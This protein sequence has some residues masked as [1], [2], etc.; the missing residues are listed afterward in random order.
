MRP[1]PRALRRVRQRG[2]CGAGTA[3]RPT[4]R[5]P[6]AWPSS[7][8]TSARSTTTTSSTRPRPG[9]ASPSVNA[10]WGNLVAILAGDF[11]LA[12]ASELAAS[13]GAEVAGAA[14][15][16]D[17][18]A[19]RGPGARAAAPLRRRP[20]RGGLLVGRSRARRP[21]CSR[22][23]AAS[24]ASSRASPT[25]RSTRSPRFGR[26]LGMCFQIVDDVLDLIATDDALGKPAGHD[27]VEGVY[28]L[29]VIYMLRESAELRELLGRPLDAEQL[30]PHARWRSALAT[31]RGRASRS[32]W[33]A[34]TRSRPSTR[35]R[36]PTASTPRVPH[37]RSP[38]RRARH[39]ER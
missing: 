34:T 32:T 26:H 24:A 8:S 39:R 15:R 18:R 5:S 11:L 25:P 29:P 7:S 35:S 27:L 16:H 2:R 31:G 23:R 28:T 3:P 9:A 6:A 10:R 14:R 20:H 22:R 21:R 12:R 1:D 17:R 37:S 36:A 19:V 4:T 13:L 33:R 38:R 30:A